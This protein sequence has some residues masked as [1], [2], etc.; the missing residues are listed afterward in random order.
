MAG[1]PRNSAQF[2]INFLG[3]KPPDFA[4]DLDPSFLTHARLDG[5]V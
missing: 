1:S 5:V 3:L 2:V 4:G